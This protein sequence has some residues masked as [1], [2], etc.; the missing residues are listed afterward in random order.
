MAADASRVVPRGRA[1]VAAALFASAAVVAAQGA[2]RRIVSLIPAVTETLFAIGA[3]PQVVA[4]SSF[5]RYP[6]EVR[7]LPKVGALVD[8]DLEKILSLRPDM[9]AVFGS[10]ADLRAQLAR[11]KVAVYLYDHGSLADVTPMIREVGSKVGRAEVADRLAR[12][13]EEKLAAIRA[14]VS[15]SPRPRT[16]IVFGRE[17]RALR[18]IYASGAVGFIN[19]I[20]AAAGGDN[21]FADM[22]QQAVQATA[23]LILA[24]RPEVILELRPEGLS[25]EEVRAER[26]TWNA[27]ASVPAV[28]NNRIYILTD[29]R[30]VVPGPRIADGTDLISRVLHP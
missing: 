13:V 4:V 14:R 9:V 25:A 18:G 26:A 8:P 16:L 2:P 6:P 11:A 15:G 28:R 30:T 3:G 12:Q 1:A 20:V 5:D 21:V 24:R 19:D 23:E 22:K 10:Q 7:A 17:A 27:L 29:A